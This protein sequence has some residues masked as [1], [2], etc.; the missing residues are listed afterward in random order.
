MVKAPKKEA[1][2]SKVTK[3]RKVQ[4]ETKDSQEDNSK[5]A[6]NKLYSA[7]NY[8]SKWGDDTPLE[9]YKLCNTNQ[10]KRAFLDKHLADKTLAR[11]RRVQQTQECNK[12]S[13]SSVLKGWY[14]QY[15]VA[16]FEKM[17]MDSPGLKAYL[18]TLQS[19]PHSKKAFADARELEY[20]YE[21][22]EKVEKKQTHEDSTILS[23]DVLLNQAHHEAMHSRLEVIFESN[24]NSE[25]IK[26]DPE[27]QLTIQ[28]K[29]EQDKT[30][31]TLCRVA[32]DILRRPV[33]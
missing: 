22:T 3:D 19:K 4:G 28:V 27:E 17:P 5:A 12:Q 31:Q 1:K 11:C 2:D 7:I 21:S 20:Y 10:Q 23:R 9:T 29:R 15:Q 33:D 18:K 26:Q 30:S 6:W 24:E 25:A 32:Q 13:E 14:N 16:D 8:A